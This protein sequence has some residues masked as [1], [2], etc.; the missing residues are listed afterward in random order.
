MQFVSDEGSHFKCSYNGPLT[1]AAGASLSTTWSKFTAFTN[2][3][4]R[5]SR[6]MQTHLNVPKYQQ[7]STSAI[8]IKEQLKT[9][10]KKK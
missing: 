1:F 3:S 10:L 6:D 5:F 9:E 8:S 4:Y 2:G 7:H